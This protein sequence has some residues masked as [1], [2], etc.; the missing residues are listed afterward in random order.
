MII[1]PVSG[2]L[3]SIEAVALIRASLYINKIFLFLNK[4]DSKEAEIERAL[5]FPKFDSE[6]EKCK[7]RLPV[8]K[9]E[10]E[11]QP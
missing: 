6:V 2:C 7:Y 4:G 10:R 11:R 5:N 1:S 3:L 9:G 8:E